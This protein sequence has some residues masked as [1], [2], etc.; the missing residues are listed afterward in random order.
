[1]FFV[2]GVF[3]SNAHVDGPDAE[4]ADWYA[5]GDPPEAALITLSRKAGLD[6]LH[7]DVS[8]PELKEFAFDSAR[9]RMS[10]IR[11][12][13]D[14]KRNYVFVKGAPESVL[15]KFRCLGSW[16]HCP[17]IKT[18]RAVLDENEKLAQVAF[19]ILA[20]PMGAPANTN[21]D[22]LTME[23]VE[24]GLTYLGMVSMMILARGSPIGYATSARCAD[25][26]VHR[27]GDYASTAQT[28]LSRQVLQTTPRHPHSHWRR[29]TKTK[30]QTDPGYYAVAP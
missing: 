10:S 29:G 7:L 21:L 13:G 30:R 2:A 1:M 4:H 23:E 9:K 15:Q 3:A 5:I 6:P 24:E 25:Q 19:V 20:L 12:W 14:G 22:S 28:I 11:A 27:T 16:T 18:S 8:Y 17:R 26:R